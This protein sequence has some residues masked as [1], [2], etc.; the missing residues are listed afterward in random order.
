[1]IPLLP[2]AEGQSRAFKIS[3]GRTEPLQCSLNGRDH[4]DDENRPH[5]RPPLSYKDVPWTAYSR[6]RLSMSGECPR[7]AILTMQIRASYAKRRRPSEHRIF[8]ICDHTVRSGYLGGPDRL[9]SENLCG[10][11]TPHLYINKARL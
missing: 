7:I 1:M 10:E 11:N 5:T 8:N 2:S 4:V 6:Q 9:R 3:T